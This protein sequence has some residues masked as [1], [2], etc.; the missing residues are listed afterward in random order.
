MWIILL[1]LSL[2]HF[3]SRRR[4]GRLKINKALLWL[5]LVMATMA[6]AQ[7]TYSIR[8]KLHLP[9]GE[10]TVY[11]YL[12]DEASFDVPFSGVDT[13]VLQPQ[14][15]ELT[16][17]F[18]EVPAGNYALRAYQDLNANQRLDRGLFGPE[19]PYGFSW[20]HKAQFPFDFEDVAFRAESNQLHS[21]VLS[22]KPF[23]AK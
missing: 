22:D 18:D 16:F 19:E 12:V 14:G 10:G 6:F 2:F 20:K 8:G 13:L 7:D 21:I 17:Y 23:W 1:F 11:L 15:Q 4:T 9:T 5:P 3:K